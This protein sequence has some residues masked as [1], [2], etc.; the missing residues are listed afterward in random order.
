MVVPPLKLLAPVRVSV[1]LPVLVSEPVPD[2]TDP[3]LASVV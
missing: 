1:P 3:K 2:I